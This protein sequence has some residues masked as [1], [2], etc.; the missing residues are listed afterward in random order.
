MTKLEHAGALTDD[1][2]A[3]TV[4]NDEPSG[5]LRNSGHSGEPTNGA[6]ACTMTDAEVAGTLT[7]NDQTSLVD[8]LGS[9]VDASL[10][11][12]SD[13]VHRE[14]RFSCWRRCVNSA[15]S[16]SQPPVTPGRPARATP[17]T[18]VRWRRGPNRS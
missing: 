5:G 15:G 11:I 9:L 7:N 3:G 16:S 1:E 4:T 2:N 17:P 8:A 14:P 13:T 6:Y 10:V 18:T 12:S